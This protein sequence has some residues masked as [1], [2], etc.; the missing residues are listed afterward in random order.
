MTQFYAWRK[1]IFQNRDMP[2]EIRVK[3]YKAVVVN[4]LLWGCETWSMTS[5]H[6]RRLESCHHTCLRSIL[7]I[8][9]FQRI[10]NS[11]TRERAGISTMR[12]MY[13]LRRARYLYKISQMDAHWCGNQRYV[14]ALLAAWKPSSEDPNVRGGHSNR[15][16]GRTCQTLRHGYRNTLRFFGFDDKDSINLQKWMVEVRDIKKWGPRVEETLGLDSGSFQSLYRAQNN[17]G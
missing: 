5:R 2:L 13:E 9:K 16:R 10:R 17:F 8:S 6:R 12:D 3:F 7:R 4:T 14:R 1:G 15:E 11:E